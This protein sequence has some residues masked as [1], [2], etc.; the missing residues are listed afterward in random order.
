M[1]KYESLVMLWKFFDRTEKERL[2]YQFTRVHGEHFS[3]N[4]F[5]KFLAK[6]Y[7]G[8]QIRFEA[9]GDPADKKA[10]S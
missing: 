5:F 4:E 8:S 7:D 9:V 1:G 10:S 3:R 6:K 2:I